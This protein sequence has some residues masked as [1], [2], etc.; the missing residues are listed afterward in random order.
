MSSL[1]F[2]IF[3]LVLILIAV[4][5][6]N[7]WI[8]RK[9]RPEYEYKRKECVMTQSERECFNALIKLVGERY[10]I[11]PQV[12]LD[13]ILNHKVYGQN[14]FGAFH[15][16]NQWSVD[17]VLSDKQNYS[18][19]L[20]IELDDRSHEHP[21]RQDR[22]KEVERILKDAKMPLLR[23]EQK[24]ILNPEDVLRKIDSHIQAGV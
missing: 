3:I 20:A 18:T 1:I 23:L 22:D 24:N 9:R 2:W 4:E 19:K 14:W 6:F 7:V 11:F 16:I 8:N 17:F 15:H 21:D 5:V 13:A 10:Y 12:H